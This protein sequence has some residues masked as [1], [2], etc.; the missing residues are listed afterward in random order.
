MDNTSYIA[1]SRQT[2]VWRQLDITANNLA[3]TNTPGFKGEQPLFVE[4]VRRTQNTDRA[5][6]DKLSF[7]QDFGIVRDLREGPITHTGNSLDIALN[8][9]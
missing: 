6:D 7:V 4:Y 5:F 9:E 2:A 3:N 8:G 1:L